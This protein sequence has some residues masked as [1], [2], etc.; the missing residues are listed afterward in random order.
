MCDGQTSG[1]YATVLSRYATITRAPRD[2]ER[3]SLSLL[4]F[5]ITLFD[6]CEATFHLMLCKSVQLKDSSTE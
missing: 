1:Y 3:M 6:T 2:I 4:K 5:L